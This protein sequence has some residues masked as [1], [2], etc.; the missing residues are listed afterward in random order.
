MHGATIKTTKDFVWKH[1][2]DWWSTSLFVTI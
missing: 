1:H 2:C